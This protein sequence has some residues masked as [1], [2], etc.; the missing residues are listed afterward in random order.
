MAQKCGNCQ[1]NWIPNKT[2]PSTVISPLPMMAPIKTGKA[3]GS[4]PTK[5]AEGPNR[6]IGVVE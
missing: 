6:F 5:T 3:P 1:K 4:A 2:K